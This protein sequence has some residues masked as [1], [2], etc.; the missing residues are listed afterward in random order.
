MS[1][2]RNRQVFADSPR[3]LTEILADDVNL[4][5]WQ[6]RLPAQVEDFAGLVLSQGQMLAD[7]RVVEVDEHQVPVLPGLLREASDMHGYAGFV[8]DVV[9]LV[10]AFT[11]LLGARRIGL[12][13]RVLEGAMCPRFHVDHV[14]LRLL[15][16][17][18]GAGSEWLEEG[19][20]DRARLQFEPAPVDNIQRLAAGE[21][22]LLKGERWLGNEGGGL[23]HRSPPTPAGERRLLLS[24]DWLA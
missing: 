4:A 6:R 24:L 21:V 2:V 19:R 13:V 8:A 16:T 1:P 17:Y 14:P 12:R 9:W 11:C 23:I 22:A 15:S 18:A 5:T 7:E 3:V 20:L 10:E